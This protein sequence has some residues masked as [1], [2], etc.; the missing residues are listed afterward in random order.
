MGRFP[1]KAFTPPFQTR[2]VPPRC[3]NAHTAGKRGTS[4]PLYAVV[5]RKV[6]KSR[7]LFTK[8][9]RHIFADRLYVTQATFCRKGNCAT[10]VR[11]CIYPPPRRIFLLRRVLTGT[12]QKGRGCALPC[13]QFSSSSSSSSKSSKSLASINSSSKSSSI[14]GFSSSSKSSSSK[15]SSSAPNASNGISSVSLVSSSSR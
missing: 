2:K 1:L 10:A 13:R 11:N 6:Q 4:M 15:S 5:F 14:S 8:K 9:R 12:K 7:Y 3:A